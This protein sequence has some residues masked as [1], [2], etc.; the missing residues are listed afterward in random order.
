MPGKCHA[1]PGKPSIH[2]QEGAVLV[3]FVKRHCC[4][5]KALK[6]NET[7]VRHGDLGRFFLSS[8]ICSAWYTCLS[9]SSLTLTK[10]RI[11]RGYSSPSFRGFRYILF[12]INTSMHSLVL[13]RR[14][15]TFVRHGNFGRMF[16]L[17]MSVAFINIYLSHCSLFFV[18]YEN[19]NSSLL[20]FTFFSKF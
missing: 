18:L 13:N 15:E 3:V 12:F 20:L 9:H 5:I 8:H 16:C 14:N 17:L 6:R 10:I 4:G 11:H 19:P 2:F 7:L 1:P